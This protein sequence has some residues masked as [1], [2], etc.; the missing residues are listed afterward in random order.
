MKTSNV[1]EYQQVPVSIL[2]DKGDAVIVI[3][4]KDEVFSIAK[5]DL[6]PSKLVTGGVYSEKFLQAALGGLVEPPAYLNRNQKSYKGVYGSITAEPVSTTQVKLAVGIPFSGLP[7]DMRPDHTGAGKTRRYQ[8]GVASTAANPVGPNAKKPSK[9]TDEDTLYMG[10]GEDGGLIKGLTLVWN[11]PMDDMDVEDIRAMFGEGKLL[12]EP[13]RIKIQKGEQTETYQKE[14]K[15]APYIKHASYY[16]LTPVM[17][18]TCPKCS[19]LLMMITEKEAKS[20]DMMPHGNDRVYTKCVICG[21]E[22]L[23]EGSLPGQGVAGQTDHE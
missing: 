16:G 9:I 13:D 23:Y 21:Y 8:D 12:P 22:A 18:R 14:A 7:A 3:N 5:A 15:G 20:K 19:S 10:A 6:K 1:F 17:S 2:R 11:E 4:S